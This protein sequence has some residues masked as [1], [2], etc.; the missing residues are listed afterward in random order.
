MDAISFSISFRY[1]WIYL[2]DSLPVPTAM[3][4]EGGI[5]GP[6]KVVFCSSVLYIKENKVVRNPRT[7]LIYSFIIY[8]LQYMHTTE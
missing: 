8:N 5:R 4:L 6:L 7:E 1:F 3:P 2:R